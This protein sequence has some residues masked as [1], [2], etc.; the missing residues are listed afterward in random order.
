MIK[1]DRFMSGV[2]MVDVIVIRDGVAIDED[3][4]VIPDVS[5]LEEAIVAAEM[6][7]KNSSLQV[8][9]LKLIRRSKKIR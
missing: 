1:S 4:L 8:V 5:E 7:R 3:T 9:S 2:W 6:K